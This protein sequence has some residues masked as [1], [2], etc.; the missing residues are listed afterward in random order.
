MSAHLSNNTT[1]NTQLGL[2][3]SKENTTNTAS[4]RNNLR[5]LELMIK[6]QKETH[7]LELEHLQQTQRLQIKQLTDQYALQQYIWVQLVEEGESR[8]EEESGDEGRDHGGREH[9][10]GR[11]HGGGRGCGT[12]GGGWRGHGTDGGG[13]K[14]VGR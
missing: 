2:S 4:L 3:R 13:W 8:S 7:K 9:G 6:E 12:H 5:R 1:T 11:G 10:T 14:A